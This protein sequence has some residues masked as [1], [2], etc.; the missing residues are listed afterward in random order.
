[1]EIEGFS[2]I[3]SIVTL[4][5]E[6]H[7]IDRRDI[8]ENQFSDTLCYDSWF[9][10]V[11]GVISSIFS[12]F[13]NDYDDGDEMEMMIFNDNVISGYFLNAW[14]FGQKTNT[15][16]DK[17]PYL[18]EAEDE[19]RRRLSFCNSMGWKLLGYAKTKKAAKQSKLIVYVGMCDCDC[20][21]HLAHSLIRLYKWFS[22]K[23]AEFAK[24]KEVTAA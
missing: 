9:E 5:K 1:M 19:V 4:A 17:N 13:Y 16:Y 7:D 3:I 6:L 8:V 24:I 20:H 22:D 14:E 10:N 11:F 2:D 12:D 21:T 18:T 15:P 23:C